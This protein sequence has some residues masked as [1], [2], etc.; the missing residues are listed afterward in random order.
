M[1]KLMETER[2]PEN[3]KKLGEKLKL[4]TAKAFAE[5]DEDGIYSA[6]CPM[7]EAENLLVIS[8]GEAFRIPERNVP[9]LLQTASH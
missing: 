8:K 9:Q 7:T 4:E 5:T 2:L 3:W 6:Y 1:G